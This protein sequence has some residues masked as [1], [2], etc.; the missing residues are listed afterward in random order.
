PMIMGRKTFESI[1]R[2]LPGRTNIVVTRDA[3]R[4]WADV[5]TVA[6][7][8]AALQRAEDLAE[9]LDDPEI[10]VIGGA[11]IY[12]AVLPRAHRIY[13]TQVHEAAE[14]DTVF[15]KLDSKAWRETARK[16]RADVYSV[17]V[18]FIVLDRVKPDT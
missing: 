9:S 1:G 4:R 11:E 8:D 18:S 14:G 5:E 2:A 6:D 17:P 12:R 15:P 16:D 3:S 10:M 13:L 7:I